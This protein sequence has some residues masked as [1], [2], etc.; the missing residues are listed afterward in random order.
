MRVIFSNTYDLESYT[1]ATVAPV[2]F[3]RLEKLRAGALW[4]LIG[5]PDKYG[6][7][8]TYHGPA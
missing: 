5:D 7:C 1:V 4:V 8:E 3:E 2:E 6:N